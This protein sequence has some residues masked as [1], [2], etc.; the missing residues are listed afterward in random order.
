MGPLVWPTSGLSET[1]RYLS[2]DKLWEHELSL[3]NSLSPKPE[4]DTVSHLSDSSRCG[5][6]PNL[7]CPTG[8]R[9][10]EIMRLSLFSHFIQIQGIVLCLGHSVTRIGH[11]VW[12]VVRLKDSVTKI[13]GL[14]S[15]ASSATY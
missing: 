2:P 11:V 3:L 12:W 10:Q 8:F 9:L 5:Y 15:E 7:Q 14:S 13:S 4:L 6:D 1:L